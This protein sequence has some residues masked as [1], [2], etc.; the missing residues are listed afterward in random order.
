MRYVSE[1]FKSLYGIFLKDRTLGKAADRISLL[2]RVEEF[3]IL[4]YVES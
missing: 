1:C 4:G 2:L 3:A